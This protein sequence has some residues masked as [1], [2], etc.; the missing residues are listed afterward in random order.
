MDQRLSFTS[1]MLSPKQR[2]NYP[3]VTTKVLGNERL[4]SAIHD[5]ARE[6]LQQ[7]Q[8]QQPPKTS[9]KQSKCIQRAQSLT[10]DKH[11]SKSVPLTNGPQTITPETMADELSKRLR[12]LT[13]DGSHTISPESS[14]VSSEASSPRNCCE[15][16]FFFSSFK[17]APGECEHDLANQSN[18]PKT[19][20]AVANYEL[21]FARLV[22]DQKRKAAQLL[23]QMKTRVSSTLLRLAGWILIKV[24]SRLFNNIH[25]QEAEL[26]TVQEVAQQRRVPIVFLPMHRSHLDYI[27]ISFVLYMKGIA[28]PLV[29]AGEN[30]N[31]PLFGN[32]MR[33]LG[34]FFIRRRMDPV[35]GTRDH[36]YRSL[37]QAYVT[38]NLKS[39]QNLEFFIEGGRSRTGKALL[40][41][42]SVWQVVLKCFLIQFCHFTFPGWFVVCRS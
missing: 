42:V 24:L 25:Y 39:G 18:H 27:V 26:Q 4:S 28:P 19:A 22:A 9:K 1:Y 8:Q 2:N 6:K 41:K 5:V 30:L 20:A 15:N 16:P 35:P 17:F 10:D 29:A 13:C 34:A 38:E 37:L 21:Q 33:G 12:G 32:L 3:D 40:P 14:G 7:R 23:R 31:I 36:V 11:D